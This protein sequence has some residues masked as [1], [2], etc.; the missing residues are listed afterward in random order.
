MSEEKTILE[1]LSLSSFSNGDVQN[2]IVEAASSQG[3]APEV[4]TAEDSSDAHGGLCSCCSD[5]RETVQMDAGHMSFIRMPGGFG[6]DPDGELSDDFGFA[7]EQA[8]FKK[9]KVITIRQ[10]SRCGAMAII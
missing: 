3:R 8:V 10:H 5:S 2:A 9:R 4:E 6:T 7:V 1:I